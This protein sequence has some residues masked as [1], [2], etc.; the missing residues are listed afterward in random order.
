MKDDVYF[1]ENYVLLGNYARDPDRFEAMDELFQEFLREAGFTV[2]QEPPH[3]EAIQ[4]HTA[5][6]EAVQTDRKSTRLNSSH[7]YISYAVFCLKKKNR[8][9]ELSSRLPVLMISLRS[10]AQ[11][12]GAAGG[13][14]RG[15][16]VAADRARGRVQAGAGSCAC[17]A[18]GH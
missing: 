18:T 11:F 9:A 17:S 14:V 3:T 12:G 8:R 10:Q 13:N 5:L 7:G 4:A 1:L 2:S 15:E 6:L 16:H